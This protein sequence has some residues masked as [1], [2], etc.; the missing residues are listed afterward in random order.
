[1]AH[2][3]DRSSPAAGRRRFLS[4]LGAGGAALG[5]WL[6][7]GSRPARGTAE[8]ERSMG[9]D[10][11]MRAAS[12]L[13]PEA[14]LAEV[15]PIRLA[16][17]ETFTRGPVAVVRLVSDRGE[18]GFGQT[19]PFNADITALV[20]HRHIAPHA[21]GA[22]VARIAAFVDRAIE[23][24]YKF[25]GSY[26]RRAL[27]GVETALW[28]LR[29]RRAGKSVCELLGGKPGAVAAYGSSMR[30]DITPEDEAARLVQLRQQ[31]GFR[32]F[33]V[34]IGRRTGHDQDQW[35]G[36]T[37]ALVK[38]VRKAIG[39]E[40]ALL[41]D[42]NSCYAPQKAIAVGRF[43]GEYGV[44]HFEEP[45]PYWEYEWT[46]AVAQAIEV[47]VAGGEQDCLLPGWRRMIQMRA[48]DIVQPDVCYVGG[49]VRALRVAA[50]GALAGM[51]CVPHSSNL[52][53][54]T[55]FTMHLLR[56]IANAGP[57]LEFSIEPTD[58]TR[59]IYRPMLEVKDGQVA[60]PEGPGWGVTIRREWLDEAEH[61]ITRRS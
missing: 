9:E 3:S 48:V 51:P 21:L 19:A 13:D 20:V 18:E 44:C 56:A 40:V 31:K 41:V 7:A 24:N 50:M 46:A 23:E 32:A 29:A 35:P 14:T 58:W 49:M 15:E 2:S 1:M 17:V 52:S 34:R 57:Y 45:C 26:V 12:E 28:D 25:P 4:V 33:K 8:A 22:P 43:L 16:S 47:P 10:S 37:E 61:R 54:V 36:R 59:D 60:F 38:T 5:A 53:L 11:A 27:T 42:A 6:A 55:V 39:P 30:R